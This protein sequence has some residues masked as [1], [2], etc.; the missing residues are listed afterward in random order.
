[1]LISTPFTAD[2]QQGINCGNHAQ[3]CVKIFSM[4]FC[5][6][7]NVRDIFAGEEIQGKKLSFRNSHKIPQ[8]AAL[9]LEGG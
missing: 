2:S 4:S 6:F 3:N 1:M 5:S 7:Q 8:S 9:K